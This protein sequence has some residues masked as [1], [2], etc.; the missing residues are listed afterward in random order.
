MRTAVTFGILLA[1]A[2]PSAG[3]KKEPPPAPRYGIEADLEAYPQGTPKA[4]LASVLRALDG[5]RYDYLAAQLGDPETVD[6]RVRELGKFETYVKAVSDRYTLDPE[7]ARELRRFASE[8]SFNESGDAATVSHKDIR[9]RQV[10]LKRIGGRWFV[11]DRSTP[12]KEPRP[13]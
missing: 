10:F 8:G 9:G 6:K 4:A 3:Q 12:A 2:G 11:E 7:A 13:Q 5:R 1:L